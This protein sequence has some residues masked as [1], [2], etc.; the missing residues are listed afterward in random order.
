MDTQRSEEGSEKAAVGDALTISRLSMPTL[1]RLAAT[2]FMSFSLI[3]DLNSLTAK[4]ADTPGEE[5]K[6]LRQTQKKKFQRKKK[7]F[8]QQVL[9]TFLDKVLIEEAVEDGG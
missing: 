2:E 7:K 4:A 1:R 6:T 3:H 8:S 5:R 9:L